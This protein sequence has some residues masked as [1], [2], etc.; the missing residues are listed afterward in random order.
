MTQTGGEAHDPRVV[1]SRAAVPEAGV[2]LLG[3]LILITC[4]VRDSDDDVADRIVDLFLA[5]HRPD[6]GEPARSA[7]PRPLPAPGRMRQLAGRAM[8]FDSRYSSRPGTP[9]SRPMPDCL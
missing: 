9:I 3:P 2:E 8:V 6:A 5:S 4:D 1:R 7:V